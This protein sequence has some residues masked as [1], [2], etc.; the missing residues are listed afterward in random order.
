M[1][2]S[3]TKQRMLN[4]KIMKRSAEKLFLS[5]TSKKQLVSKV[6]QCP[7]S[8]ASVA[9]TPGPL[10]FDIEIEGPGSRRHVTLD[11]VKG[12]VSMDT[13][14]LRQLTYF[15]TPGP[16]R[17]KLKGGPGYTRLCLCTHGFSVLPGHGLHSL[18]E[19]AVHPTLLA[20]VFMH[21]TTIG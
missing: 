16:P 14:T 11:M 5:L 6:H 17:A 10:T 2:G 3:L 19:F 1:E 8:S 12:G 18:D 13:P 9:S 15:C 7:T 4:P 20:A 21:V